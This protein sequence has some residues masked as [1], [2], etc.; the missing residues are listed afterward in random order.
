[1]GNMKFKAE[2]VL[3][4]ERKKLGCNMVAAR[5]NNSCREDSWE[6]GTFRGSH[7]LIQVG[8]T[9]EHPGQIWKI[10]NFTDDGA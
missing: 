7:I 1:M 2:A 5:G 10:R 3:Y 8:Q 6:S 9:K 4:G